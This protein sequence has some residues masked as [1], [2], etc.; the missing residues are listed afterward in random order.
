M[1]NLQ[2]ELERAARVKRWVN[3]VAVAL[4]QFLSFPLPFM[5][6]A[7]LGGGWSWLFMLAWLVGTSSLYRRHSRPLRMSILVVGSLLV[8][9]ASPVPYLSLWWVAPV[10]VYHGARY[11]A[12]WVRWSALVGSVLASLVG[13][14]DFMGLFVGYGWSAGELAVTFGVAVF[15]CLATTVIAWFFGDT[16]RLR[17]NRQRALIERNRQLEHE[18]EQERVMAALDER[19]RIAREMHDIVAHSLSVIIA[20]AD[21]ARYAAGA[22]AAASTG[23]D[24]AGVSAQEPVELTALGTISEAARSSLAQ[25]RSLLGVLRTDEGG[26]FQPLPALH[27]V[28]QLVEA[29]QAMGIP[30]RL[31][32][33]SGVEDRLPRGAD[34][35]VYRIVQEALTNVT[36]HC[37]GT[38]LVTVAITAGAKSLD[39]EVTNLPQ[40]EPSEPL[41]GARR[42]LLG[43]RERVDMYGG[44]LHYG[45]LADGSFRVF[46]QIPWAE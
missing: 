43:M 20:Q 1:D 28:P 11:G 25:M 15:M 23:G 6:G 45:R 27:N 21:G 40:A 9:L 8:S 35:T 22:R 33:V 44:S 34:L 7:D 46:A 12:P 4:G 32:L 42:G 37:P 16:R 39:I 30:A 10:A 41:P 2:A 13:G 5:V 26:S 18:R 36:R 3:I 17:E 14:W 29:V 31:S 38:P 24:G 19:A